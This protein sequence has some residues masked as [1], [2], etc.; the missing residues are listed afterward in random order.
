MQ[1]SRKIAELKLKHAHE[2][3]EL[4]ASLQN[5]LVKGLDPIVNYVPYPVFSPTPAHSPESHAILY[6]TNFRREFKIAGQ[7]AEPNKPDKLTYVALINQIG[8]GI[9]RG[10]HESEVI[11]AIIK[12]ITRLAVYTIIF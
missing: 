9:K 12:E 3:Q 10:C 6:P 7:A 5:S 2:L 1:L 8:N 11:D 4:K